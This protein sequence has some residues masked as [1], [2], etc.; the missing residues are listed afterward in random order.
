MTTY[1][2]INN[3]YDLLCDELFEINPNHPNLTKTKSY[4]SYIKYSKSDYDEYCKINGIRDF[5]YHKVKGI[6]IDYGRSLLRSQRGNRFDMNTNSY[7]SFDFKYGKTFKHLIDIIP[8]VYDAI[9]N[10]ECDIT[11]IDPNNKMDEFTDEEWEKFI[12][13]CIKKKIFL[14]TYIK[15]P[16]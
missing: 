12:N 4:E 9:P 5:D 6:L 16:I 11:Y 15:I 8:N 1:L 14:D 2:R 7:I 10:L 13:N 3:N